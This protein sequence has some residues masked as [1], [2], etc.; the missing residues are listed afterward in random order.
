MRPRLS[1]G[2]PEID[3]AAA[4]HANEVLR[5]VRERVDEISETDDLTLDDCFAIAAAVGAEMQAGGTDGGPR[6]A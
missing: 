4:A 3:E 2:R 6:A 1:G 5:V